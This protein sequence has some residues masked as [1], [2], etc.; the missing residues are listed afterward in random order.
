MPLFYTGKGD[1]GTSQIGK[2]KIPKDSLIVDTLG[3]L[4]EL[5]SLIGVS[6][7]SLKNKELHDKL[8]HIQE[9]LF[10]IQARVAWIMF[11]EYEDGDRIVPVKPK[12]LAKKRIADLEKEVDNIEEKIKPERGF[13]ISGED[14]VAAQ[15][16]YMRAVSRRVERKIDTLHKKHELPPEILAYMN[17]LSSY[18]YA[19]ARFEIFKAKIKESNPIYE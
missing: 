7:G 6:R 8:K 9:A 2:K 3:D 1:K 10:I 18:L 19:L 5:N 13:I 4:D 12:I 11:P 16:D 15:L 14:S 17:R